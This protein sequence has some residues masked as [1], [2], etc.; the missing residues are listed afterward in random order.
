MSTTAKTRYISPT[1]VAKL[2]RKDLR[3]VFKGAKFSVRT[4]KYSGGSSINVTWEDGPTVAAVEELIGH[5]AGATF[6]GQTDMLSH[7]STLAITENGLEEISYGN[8]YL[9]CSRYCTPEGNRRLIAKIAEDN[10]WRSFDETFPAENIDAQSHLYAD[11]P[12]IGLNNCYLH[13]GRDLIQI[14]STV[15]DLR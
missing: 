8:D 13:T 9:F 4:S 3:A 14:Y 5:Y 11:L 2:V 12:G 10:P 7:H 6:D 1:D 15:T